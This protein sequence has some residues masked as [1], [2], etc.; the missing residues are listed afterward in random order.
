MR[1]GLEVPTKNE[2]STPGCCLDRRTLAAAHT[3]LPGP[4]ATVAAKG[5]DHGGC[6]TPK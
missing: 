3:R 1:R 4:A 5:V 2:Y 6:L